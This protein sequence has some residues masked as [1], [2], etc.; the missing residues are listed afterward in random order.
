M[1]TNFLKQI[2]EDVMMSTVQ[3]LTPEQREELEEGYSQML[4]Q[5]IQHTKYLATVFEENSRIFQEK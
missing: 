5:K 1:V 3:N 4:H 2:K